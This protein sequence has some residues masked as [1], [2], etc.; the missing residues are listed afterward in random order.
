MSFTADGDSVFAI[1]RRGRACLWPVADAALL[2]LVDARAC[3]ALVPQERARFA[4]FLPSAD[5]PVLD[6]RGVG[7]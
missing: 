5:Q 2:E 3:R 7:R 6:Q 4:A 1:G